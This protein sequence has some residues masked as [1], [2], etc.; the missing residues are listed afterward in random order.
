MQNCFIPAHVVLELKR[1]SHTASRA[2]FCT[3]DPVSPDIR[4]YSVTSRW[5]SSRLPA[6]KSGSKHLKT[7]LVSKLAC[8]YLLKF[9]FTN[10]RC[11]QS[12]SAINPGI[13]LRTPY[14]RACTGWCSKY[15]TRCSNNELCTEPG[16]LWIKTAGDDIAQWHW[17]LSVLEIE[18][19]HLPG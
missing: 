14:L 7:A 13:A 8:L 9:G 6:L 4:Q 19:D 18:D 5:A 1:E 15:K 16:A 3:S 17:L 11:G 2:H 12:F 10:T